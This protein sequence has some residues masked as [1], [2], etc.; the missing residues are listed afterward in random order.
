[1]CH[2]TCNMGYVICDMDQQGLWDI[3]S[4]PHTG[5]MRG[6]LC[7]PDVQQDYSETGQ[8]LGDE[9]WIRIVDG[10]FALKQEWE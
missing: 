5:R 7:E 2:V 8:C 3:N 1:M 4:G 9:R 10:R 6:A